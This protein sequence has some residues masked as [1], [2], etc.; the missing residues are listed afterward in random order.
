MYSSLLMMELVRSSS[1]RYHSRFLSLKMPSLNIGRERNLFQSDMGPASFL[2]WKMLINSD[3]HKELQYFV[4]AT[5]KVSINRDINF[6]HQGN[7]GST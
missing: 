4:L 7:M 6:K 3:T 2:S 1:K 5:S